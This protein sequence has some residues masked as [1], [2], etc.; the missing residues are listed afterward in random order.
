MEVFG[1]I[2]I[3]LYG[4]ACCLLSNDQQ[5]SNEIKQ[6]DDEL[7]FVSIVPQTFEE[8][9]ISPSQESESSIE[10]DEENTLKQ[11]YS[12]PIEDMEIDDWESL[13]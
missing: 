7:L 1:C 13:V 3:G 9:S 2:M 12:S 8:R 11:R 10:K 5:T 4:M 6:K